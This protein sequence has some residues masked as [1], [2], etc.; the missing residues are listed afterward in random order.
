M[1]PHCVGDFVCLTTRVWE[2]A[3]EYLCVCAMIL[4]AMG[5]GCVQSGFS[6][7]ASCIHSMIHYTQVVWQFKI[8]IFGTI[9]LGFYAH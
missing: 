2:K 3:I 8:R 4:L 6:H 9:R 5:S 7:W 1:T